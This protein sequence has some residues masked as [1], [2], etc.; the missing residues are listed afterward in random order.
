[1][2]ILGVTTL[3]L[4]PGRCRDVGRGEGIVLGDQDHDVGGGDLPKRQ[5]PEP[6]TG[7]PRRFSP[8]LRLVR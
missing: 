7:R 4:D 2:N 1:M 5:G 3:R 6:L 8:K